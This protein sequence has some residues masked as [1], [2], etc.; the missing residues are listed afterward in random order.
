MG[1]S[2]GTPTIKATW[3]DWREFK[4]PPLVSSPVTTDPDGKV[5]LQNAPG[6]G[7]T[8]PTRETATTEADVSVGGGERA[9][10]SN[11]H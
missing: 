10:T 5:V 11:Q 7:S 6:I 3:I 1:V 4:D 2:S 9:R 8:N